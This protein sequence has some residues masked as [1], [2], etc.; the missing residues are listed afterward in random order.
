MLHHL[1][2]L[3]NGLRLIVPGLLL[4]LSPIVQAQQKL[5]TQEFVFQGAVYDFTTF[6]EADGKYKFSVGPAGVDSPRQ[7]FTLRVI[8]QENID[9]FSSHFASAM[10]KLASASYSPAD[11]SQAQAL[12]TSSFADS[13]SEFSAAEKYQL[14]QLAEKAATSKSIGVAGFEALF[15]GNIPAHTGNKSFFQ[16]L[17]DQ[18]GY[19]HKD[20]E[21]KYQEELKQRTTLLY[22]RIESASRDII[23]HSNPIGA[24][25]V[26]EKIKVFTETTEE[27]KRPLEFSCREPKSESAL[28]DVDSLVIEFYDGTIKDMC[29]FTH[30]SCGAI[31]IFSNLMPISFSSKYDITKLSARSDRNRKLYA[32][33]IYY[34]QGHFEN[35]PTTPFVY[36]D[37]VLDYV[38]FIKLLTEDYSPS[39][40]VVTVKPGQ[41]LMQLEK[42]T[43][44]QIVEARIY[45]DLVGIDDDQPN[46]LIQV[47]AWKKLMLNTKNFAVFPESEPNS[48]IRKSAKHPDSV[49]LLN[50]K[51]E[52]ANGRIWIKPVN[53]GPNL[54]Q[55]KTKTKIKASQ[56]CNRRPMTYQVASDRKSLIIGNHPKITLRKN[57]KRV[58][59]EGRTLVFSG[60]DTIETNGNR[61]TMNGNAI[62]IQ[63]GDKGSWSPKPYH[64]WAYGT[65][66]PHITPRLRLSDINDKNNPLITEPIVVPSGGNESDTLPSIHPLRL[67]QYS[68]LNIGTSLGLFDLTVNNLKST[69]SIAFDAFLSRSNVYMSDTTSPTKVNAMLLGPSFT[70]RI[71]PHT[72]TEAALSYRIDYM[73]ALVDG[74]VTTTDPD[75]YIERQKEHL[76]NKIFHSLHF[77]GIWRVREE[78]GYSDKISLRASFHVGAK[79]FNTN[80]F[81]FQ[82]GYTMNLTMPN[83]IPKF[84]G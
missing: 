31:V 30:T 44:S 25:R 15:A 78:K 39:N 13:A 26:H 29:L 75:R 5:G 58:I 8:S 46:G 7:T 77:A 14:T 47:E 66:L 32:Y 49:E 38:R 42:E 80:F 59:L 61:I 19:R 57:P 72:H 50:K 63:R 12:V 69:F 22:N 34:N 70:W 83:K 21:G 76:G 37:E 45:S 23:T 82:I 54:T 28:L 64:I 6:L 62:K 52:L 65:W 60:F 3:P 56:S 41:P 51:V 36:I 81:Q 4:L 48:V 9:V 20:L 84:G 73:D 11:T 43:T 33:K 17:I 18:I 68:N 55:P 24:I 74:L 16:N 71:N 1:T 67:F 79:S 10:G 2:T 40:Q 53:S 35:P 27:K